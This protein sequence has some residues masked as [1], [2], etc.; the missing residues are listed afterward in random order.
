MKTKLKKW[1]IVL[2]SFVALMLAVFTSLFSLKADPVDDETGEILTD[3]WELGVVFYDSTIDSGTTPLTEINWD[4]STGDYKTEERRTITIQINYKN[5]S[6]I[7]TYQPGELEITVPNLIYKNIITQAQ[8]SASAIVGANDATHTG[9]E[10]NFTSG[11][12]PSTTPEYYCF[13]NANVIEA[14]S[15]FEGSIQIQYTINSKSENSDTIEKFEN[16]CIHSYS[17]LLQAQLFYDKTNEQNQVERI[18]IN[19]NEINFSYT[20]TYPH[21]WQYPELTV[22]KKAE[23][24]DSTLSDMVWD[25]AEDPTDYYWIQYK[26]MA[27]GIFENYTGEIYPYPYIPVANY[28]F[29]DELPDNCIIVPKYSTD[30]IVVENNKYTITVPHSRIHMVETQGYSDTERFGTILIVGYPKSEYQQLENSRMTN[31]VD[32]SVS[33]EDEPETFVY[34]SQDDVSFYLSSFVF[35]YSGD[36]YGIK[37]TFMVNSSYEEIS[38]IDPMLSTNNTVHLNLTAIYT[39]KPIDVKFGDDLLYITQ[40]DGSYRRIEPEEYYF[41]SA[42][43][44]NQFYNG[45]SSSGISLSNYDVELWIKTYGNS[46]YYLYRTLKG[47]TQTISFTEEQHVIGYYFIIKNLDRSIRTSPPSSGGANPQK[48]TIKFKNI[49]NIA[50]EGKIY[51]FSYIEVYKENQLVNTPNI[52]SYANFITKEEIASFDLETYGHYMQRSCDD[53]NYTYYEI[54]VDTY[55]LNT[56]K[57]LSSPTQDA[58]NEIFTGTCN[59]SFKN[60]GYY[61]GLSWTKHEIKNY[62]TDDDK[63]VGFEFFDLLPYGMELTSTEDEIFNSFKY[64]SA[65]T[66]Y[67]AV[68]DKE[69]NKISNNDFKQFLIDGTTLEVIENY[70]NTNRDLIHILIKFEDHPLL[71]KCTTNE[72]GSSSRYANI[73]DFS[74]NYE[75]SYDAYLEYGNSWTNRIYWNYYK[76][77][78]NGSTCFN[79]SSS[80]SLKKDAYGNYIDTFDKDM[81]DINNDGQNDWTYSETTSSAQYKTNTFN[82]AVSTITINSVA[83]THQDVTTYVKTDQSYYSTGTVDASCDSEYEYKLRVRTGAADVTNLIIYSNLEE[84]QPERTRWKGEFLGFDTS[85]SQN[86][87]YNVKPYYSENPTAGNLYNEDGSLNSDWKEYFY[88][89]LPELYQNGLEVKFNSQ[90]KTE[91][92]NFDYVEIYYVLDGITYKLGKWGG[93][94]IAN[95]TILIPSN[96]FYLYWHTDY[97][98]SNYYGFSIDSIKPVYIKSSTSTTGTLPSYTAEEICDNVYPDSAFDSYTHENYGNNINKMWHYTYTEEFQKIQDA[99]TATDKAKV[100]SLAFEYLDSEGNPAI[101]PKNSINYILIQMKSP[102]DENITT[103]A[104]MDC[105]TQWNAL[106]EF[107]QP[108]DFITGINSNVVKVALPNSVDEDSNPSISLRFTKEITGTDSE[109]ENMKL[110]KASQQSFMIRLTDLAANEDGSYNQITALL[111]S[112][113]ELIISQI[114]IGTYLLEELGDNYFDFVDFTNNNDPEIIIEGVTLEKALIGYI[115]TVS[116]DLSE[117]IEFNIKVTNEI[118]PNRFYEDKNSQENLFLKNKIEENE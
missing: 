7:T 30:T 39:G 37:K 65:N 83:S 45:Y 79:T 110:D 6:A 10:W 51:N 28:K 58:T 107:G 101:I 75:I 57:T 2:M 117:N 17:T 105:W 54:D 102:V 3:N 118:E 86:K 36:L 8:W 76:R 20:R 80:Y 109:F 13:T 56:N 27:R 23:R 100:K 115:L 64:L 94:D 104:R 42:N 88:E 91:S 43:F 55:S 63:I 70:K 96:N 103:L 40:S 93:T 87:G 12:S 77:S 85:Y 112:D 108:V 71:I 15:N 78:G 41:S 50:E 29:E 66:Y 25:Y 60:S 84:A 99:T 62:L 5:N 1:H 52:D 48:A 21:P 32:L 72:L 14:N 11:N 92:V 19:S 90:C 68:Y 116:E 113:Q 74:Y 44:T 81:L 38:G 111:K 82:D 67:L 22:V 69:G 95:K 16:E 35:S 4:A 31:I 46:E 47:T 18:T 97:S 49:E 34:Q 106:N 24:L 9:F 114:P 61:N 73:F 89:T 98:G 59:V 33:Y 53:D 26:F